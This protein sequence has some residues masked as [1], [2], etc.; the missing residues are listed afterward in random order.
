MKQVLIING[1]YREEGFTDAMLGIMEAKLK[2][3]DIHVDTVVLRDTPIEFC[4]NCRHCTQVLGETPGEC[5]IDDGMRALVHRLEAADGFIFASPTNYGTVTALFK[6]FLERM[7]VYGY[8]PW[9]SPSPK[10]RKK[11]TKAALCISSCAAP[12]LLGR[13]DYHTLKALKMAARNVGAKVVDTLLVGLVPK[14]GSIIISAYDQKRIVKTV[15]RL[16]KALDI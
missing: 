10:Y 2:E 16:I 6:R 12:S 11:E 9:G 8:W 7:V 5:V 4:R 15:Q 14:S 13:V 3:A 1:S